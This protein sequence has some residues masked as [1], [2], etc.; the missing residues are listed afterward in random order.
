M[1]NV[2][3]KGQFYEGGINPRWMND[4]LKT[5]TELSKDHINSRNGHWDLKKIMLELRVCATKVG[6][7]SVNLTSILG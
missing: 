5:Y 6:I 4:H 7:I 1:S 2:W 3:P